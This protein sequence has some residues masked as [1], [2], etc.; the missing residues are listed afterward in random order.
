[1]TPIEFYTEILDPGLDWLAEFAGAP[2]RSTYADVML[3]A[4][5]QQ[6]SGLKHRAQVIST[7]AKAG[8]A[9]GWWQFERGGGVVGVLTH[10]QT[11]DLAGRVCEAC[12]V[13]RESYAVWRCLEGHDR[14][15]A[16]FARLLL[17]TD[18]APLP[19]TSMEGWHEYQAV[20]RP[21]RPHP[22]TWPGNWMRA[23]EALA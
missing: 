20:W 1:M 15:A 9:R 19:E 10:P 11:K 22:T 13:P 16:A 12:Y 7:G 2:K 18:P 17:W 8:P 3:L 6:E 14:L 4:I 5:A 21:G 23:A